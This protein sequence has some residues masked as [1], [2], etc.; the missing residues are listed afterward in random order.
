[1][2]ERVLEA[3][4]WVNATYSGAPGYVMAPETG[5]TGWPTMYSLTRALQI[6][7]GVGAPSNTFGP[8]TQ[9]A[10]Q[11]ISPIGTGSGAPVNVVKILQCALWCKG[12]TAGAI[13]GDF[14]PTLTAAV[15][16]VRSD[17]GVGGSVPARIAP[18]GTI[19]AKLFKTILTMDAYVRVGTGT[20]ESRVC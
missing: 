2:D 5:K 12:Y 6:E 10:V 11:A 19:D 16:K 18:A 1:M 15:Q 13:D 7:L 8:A 20:A 3:Q 17:L 14:G 9:A 4:Q